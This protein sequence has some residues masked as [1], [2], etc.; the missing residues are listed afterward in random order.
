ME[1]SQLGGRGAALA[2][3][4]APPSG[5]M[6]GAANNARLPPVVCCCCCSERNGSS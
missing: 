3:P 5:C 4:L 2:A 6:I 1:A